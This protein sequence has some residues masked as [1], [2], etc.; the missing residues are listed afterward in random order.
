MADEKKSAAPVARAA[1]HRLIVRP[2]VTE[3][4]TTARETIG[5]YMFEVAEGSTKAGIRRAVERMF[6]VSVH[7]VNV[8]RR[9][10]KVRRVRNRPGLTKSTKRAIVTLSPGQKIA[11]FEGI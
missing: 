3:K 1:D 6:A 8:V 11:F 7:R 4:T 10:G 5:K 2:I 9:H